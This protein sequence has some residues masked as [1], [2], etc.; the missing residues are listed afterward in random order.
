MNRKITLLLAALSL[1]IAMKSCVYHDVSDMKTSE[2]TD[3]SLF[4][5][6]GEG[7]FIYFQ[8]GSTLS[9]DPASPHGLFKLRFNSIAGASLDSNGELPAGGKFKEGSLVV[10]EVYQNN[11]LA[12]YAV[13]KKAPS[14]NSSGNGWLWS[15]YALD[16][17]PL[18][19]IEG[20]GAGCINCHSNTPNRDLVRTFD[21]H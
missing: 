5:E 12:V 10:K 14:D 19:S 13:M 6:I 21:L 4:D 1:F 18:S 7:G 9:P 20:Q 3:Q 11:N 15:E 16:G 17:T 2:N 8:N